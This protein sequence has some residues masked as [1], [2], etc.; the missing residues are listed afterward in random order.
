MKVKGG[1]PG[2]ANYPAGNLKVTMSKAPEYSLS[3]RIKVIDK[4]F[5]P[6]SNAY[7]CTN[8]KP[9]KT[10]PAYSFGVR[11]SKKAPP[12]IVPCDKV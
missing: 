1:S 11:H 5:T 2:P 9:G 3:P 10:A 12:M 4:R 6:G 8:Y 7:D